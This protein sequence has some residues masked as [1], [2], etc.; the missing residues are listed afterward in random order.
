MSEYM[1]MNINDIQP[2]QLYINAQKLQDVL[3]W[4]NPEDCDSY[5]P[6]PI[7]K[8]NG[9]I[10]FTDGH[11]RA[12]ATYLKGIEKIKVYWDEDVLD[13]NAY[14]ICV[15]WCNDEGIKWI[16]DL[17]SRV[18][19]NSEYEVLWLE[20]CKNMHKKLCSMK[21]IN[22]NDMKIIIREAVKEDAKLLIEYLNTIGGE[23]DFL[24]F[25]IGEFGKS[26]EQE[27]QFITNVSNEGNTLFI[28]AEINMNTFKKK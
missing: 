18:I 8:L 2:S 24:T 9:K 17:E 19:N 27:E 13:W 16:K 25:G 21:E 23:S 11:T 22:R 4:F 5:D 20:R 12:Y 3:K 1:L 14:Q 7:K 6:I 26:V 28:I 10:I 15:D